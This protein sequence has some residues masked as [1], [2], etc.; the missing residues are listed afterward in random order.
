MAI[1]EQPQAANDDAAGPAPASA[2]HAPYIDCLTPYLE[3]GEPFPPAAGAESEP[4][5]V[6]KTLRL[7]R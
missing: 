5:D 6:A 2:P 3:G 4:R 1:T 7:V